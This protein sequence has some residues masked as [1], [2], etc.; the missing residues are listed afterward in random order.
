MSEKRTVCCVHGANEQNLPITG[1]SVG[2]YRMNLFHALNIA[3]GATALINDNEVDEQY[4]LSAGETVEFLNRRGAK[5]VGEVW[6]S[7]DEIKARF[8]LS[9][10]KYDWWRSLGLPVHEFDDG[11]VLMTETDFDLWSASIHRPT[12]VEVEQFHPLP[13][14]SP[15][16]TIEQ[17]ARYL[18][19]TRKAIYGLLDRGKLRK[20]EGS[21]VCYFTTDMLDDFLRGETT[22]G[23]GLRPGGRKKN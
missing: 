15:Y 12:P 3:P 11:S 9:D 13:V 18:G 8:G 2:W 6:K 19:K 17:A 4:V 1:K 5:G 22:N 7:K 14:E 21:H 16:L 10:L 23:R 20:M